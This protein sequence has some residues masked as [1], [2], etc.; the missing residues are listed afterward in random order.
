MWD[1][2]EGANQRGTTQR[3]TQLW[4]VYV[5]GGGDLEWN[6]F[7]VRVGVFFGCVGRGRLC[8]DLVQCMKLY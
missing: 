1:G 8:R 4:L 5:C 7:V 2:G 3:V 6:W